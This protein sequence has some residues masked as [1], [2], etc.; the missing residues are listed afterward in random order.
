MFK[1]IFFL[2]FE[3]SLSEKLK[4]CAE[5]K[6]FVEKSGLV[7][8]SCKVPGEISKYG[9][10]KL[11]FRDSTQNPQKHD[12]EF[13]VTDEILQVLFHICCSNHHVLGFPFCNLTLRVIISF[14]RP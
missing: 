3:F 4:I 2:F 12:L 13:E 10:A 6:Y 5:E 1:T 9:I 11:F 8:I 14:S 7:E